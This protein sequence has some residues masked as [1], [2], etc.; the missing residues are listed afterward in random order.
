M[1]N[2]VVITLVASRLRHSRNQESFH[3]VAIETVRPHQQIAVAR[4]RFALQMREDD[5]I[6]LKPLRLVDGHHLHK[7]ASVLARTGIQKF[8]TRFEQRE[9]G[10]SPAFIARLEQREE[11]GCILA[12]AILNKSGG[13]T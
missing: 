2:E 12:L 3:S 5:G 13:T 10:N 7:P 1:L 11:T 6:E 9:I 4:A 8:Q